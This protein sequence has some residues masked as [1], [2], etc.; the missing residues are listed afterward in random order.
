MLTLLTHFAIHISCIFRVE[1]AV[2]EKTSFHL[3]GCGRH[4]A[5][6]VLRLLMNPSEC[7]YERHWPEQRSMHLTPAGPGP[8]RELRWGGAITPRILN[9][10]CI[11]LLKYRIF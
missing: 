10:E 6:H 9:R 2:K 11:V 3:L 8:S 5:V 1:N 4:K 7:T